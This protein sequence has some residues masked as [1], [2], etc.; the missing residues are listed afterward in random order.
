MSLSPRPAPSCSVQAWLPTQA[1]QGPWG[2]WGYHVP[3]GVG[4]WRVPT[5]APRASPLT[6]AVTRQDGPHA[7]TL[8]TSLPGQVQSTPAPSVATPQPHPGTWGA[9]M[10]GGFLLGGWTSDGLWVG[11]IQPWK[12][13]KAVGG[14]DSGSLAFILCTGRARAPGGMALGLGRFLPYGKGHAMP[15]DAMVTVSVGET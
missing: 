11:A 15:A 8:D 9:H 14:G 1:V 10:G 3:D 6:R 7:H 12:W 5:P 13:T 2:R 4:G